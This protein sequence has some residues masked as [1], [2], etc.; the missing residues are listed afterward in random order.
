MLKNKRDSS[1]LLQGHDRHKS[2]LSTINDHESSNLLVS[3]NHDSL[4]NSHISQ[5]VSPLKHK[6]IYQIAA[7]ATNMISPASSHS[8][9]LQQK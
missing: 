2:Q 6:N 9:L 1:R 7:N 5:D 3:V 4:I 8:Q